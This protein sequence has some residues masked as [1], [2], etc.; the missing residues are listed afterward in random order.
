[1][2]PTPPPSAPDRALVMLVVTLVLT[3][4]TTLALSSD[5]SGQDG[6]APDLD[7]QSAIDA[8]RALEDRARRLACYDDIPGASVTGGNAADTLAFD[9]PMSD[10]RP[11]ADAVA[12]ETDSART[13]AVPT[14]RSRMER[15][16]ELDDATH[17]GLLRVRAHNPVYLLPVRYTT[18]RN[19]TPAIADDGEPAIEP[20]NLDPFEAKFQLSLKAKVLDNLIADNGDLWVGYTQQS[21]WQAFNSAESEPFRETNYAPEIFTTWRTGLDLFGWRWQMINLGF[22]HHSNGRSDPLS[23]S[24]NRVFATLGFERDDLQLYIRPWIR[25]DEGSSDDN[26]DIE[27]YMGRGDV[28]LIWHR[29]KHDFELMGRYSPGDQRGAVQFD[30]HYPIFGDLKA[31]LQLFTG[32]GETLIDYDHRQTTIGVG[33]SVVR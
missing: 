31:Y 7:A 14:R 2:M 29:G 5:A 22:I 26:P 27:D 1:M 25:I 21:N 6:L 30:W 28:R 18:R 19:E 33:V 3:S 10:E 13:P 8:C 9:D 16:W 15:D 32:Y 4:V 12:S 11:D 23:R 20:L 24:W 17:G